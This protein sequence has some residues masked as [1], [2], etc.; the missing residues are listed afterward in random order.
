MKHLACVFKKK[1]LNLLHKI[2]LMTSF[3]VFFLQKHNIANQNK[4][5]Y[6]IF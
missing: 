1:S 2:Y 6:I 5:Y 3:V 4:I